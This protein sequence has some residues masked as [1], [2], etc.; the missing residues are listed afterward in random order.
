MKRL[1]GIFKGNINNGAMASNKIL[2]GTPDG[3]CFRNIATQLEHPA[4]WDLLILH[5]WP[6]SS[7]R[8][9]AGAT[10]YTYIKFLGKKSHALATVTVYKPKH[11]VSWA[12]SGDYEM[13]IY[14][15]LEP[16]STGTLVSVTLAWQSHGWLGC[17]SLYRALQRKRAERLLWRMLV[18][19]KKTVET[20]EAVQTA[21]NRVAPYFVE[22]KL[23]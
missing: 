15:Q 4:E 12:L 5:V 22:G 2:I 18:K 13:R 9:Q 10:S 21:E 6:V 3:L 14:W 7:M 19:L 16:K 8:I 23:S 20:E 11:T 17:F 1:L